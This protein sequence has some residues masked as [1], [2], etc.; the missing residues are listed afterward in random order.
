MLQ[1]D[2]SPLLLDGIIAFFLCILLVKIIKKNATRFGLIDIPNDRSSHNTPTPR[3]AGIAIFSSFFITVILFHFDFFTH[4]LAFFAALFLIF[5]L[6]IY[7]DVKNTSARFKL[8]VISLASAIIFILNGFAIETL[9]NWFGYDLTLPYYISMLFTIFAVVGFTNALNLID[10]LDGLAGS[11]SF[12]IIASLFYIGYIYHDQF[13]ILVS[14][15]TLMVLLSFLIFNWYPASIFMGD[16]GSLTLG[17]IIAV[18]AIRATTYVSDTAILFIAAIPII[19][20]VIVMTRRI[21]RGVSPFSPD[22]THIHHRI[23]NIKKSIDGSVHI[24]IALQIILSSIG[25]LL[26]DKSDFINLVLFLIILFVFFQVLDSREEQRDSLFVSKLKLLYI[27][28]FRKR[29]HCETAY[30][31][32]IILVLLFVLKLF[33]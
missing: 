6:G 33:L 2:K 4:Y 28:K 20:T 5:I 29:F 14:F 32:I 18:L 9:G 31:V 24:I 23:V 1:I 25:L 26:R 15:I 12:I 16:S 21:Q 22:K 19:D 8:L 10:G 3:G 7:D 17:F 13:M 30:P 11:L 27:E